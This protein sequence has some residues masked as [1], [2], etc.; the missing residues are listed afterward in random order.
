[1][2]VTAI[3]FY[4]ENGTLSGGFDDIFLSGLSGVISGGITGSYIHSKS[5]LQVSNPKFLNQD[6]KIDWDTYAPN[7]G[8]VDGS[9]LENQTLKQGIIIDRYGSKYGNYTAPVDTPFELR[10][11]PY[12]DNTWAYHKYKVVK[13]I[14][15]V[16]LSEIASAFDQ[17]GEGL[18]FELPDSVKN[19][20]KEGYLKEIF[21]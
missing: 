20:V 4:D 10:S 11:L 13:D 6:G 3:D 9:V 1:M 14:D 2:C 19:L 17:S 8:R 16:T 15:G 18:Q 12:D 21:F 5:Q 7:N